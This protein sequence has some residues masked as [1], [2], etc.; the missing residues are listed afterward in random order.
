ML[1]LHSQ[2]DLL[3][4][5]KAYQLARRAA[6]Q[7]EVP[8]GAVLVD[9][10]NQCLSLGWNQVILKQDPTAHAEMLAIQQAAKKTQNYRLEQTTLYTTLEPCCMCAGTIVHARIA[11][12]VFATRDFKAGAAGSLYNLLNGQGLNHAVQ[13]DEGPLQHECATIL[14]DF[15]Q[16]RR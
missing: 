11:R 12:L 1:A 9:A 3:W 8:V 16:A 2:D 7:G 4:M 15:F 14:T 6:S 10:N 5:Q 13:I